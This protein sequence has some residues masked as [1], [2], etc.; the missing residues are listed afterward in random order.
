M[1]IIPSR[2]NAQTVLQG[3]HIEGLFYL[4]QSFSDYFACCCIVILISYITIIESS[5]GYAAVFLLYSVQ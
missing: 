3:K 4:D 1:V 2:R 5:S